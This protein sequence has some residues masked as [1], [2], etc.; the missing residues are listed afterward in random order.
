MQVLFL[1]DG[2]WCVV[3]WI[4]PYASLDHRS[5]VPLQRGFKVH[6]GP[7]SLLEL[8]PCKPACNARQAC[9]VT[10]TNR[11]NTRVKWL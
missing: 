9:G 10:P 1:T 2:R 4:D 11:E 3:N 5:T 8:S 7:T 6:I